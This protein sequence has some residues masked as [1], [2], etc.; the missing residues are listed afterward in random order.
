MVECNLPLHTQVASKDFMTFLISLLKTQ[1]SSELQF[2]V[3]YLIKEW[4]LRFESKKDV[5]PNFFECYNSLLK[6]GVVFPDKLE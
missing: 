4:G 5:L 1:D 2:K 3:F 6:G